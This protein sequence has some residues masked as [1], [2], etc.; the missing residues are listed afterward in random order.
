MQ[1]YC[2]TRNATVFRTLGLRLLK[3]QENLG[4]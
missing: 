1:L 4:P 3:V 2:A